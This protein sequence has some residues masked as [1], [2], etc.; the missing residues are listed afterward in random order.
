MAGGMCQRRLMN[1]RYTDPDVLALLMTFIDAE[2]AAIG[3]N[4]ELAP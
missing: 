4:T 3:R 1:A 2:I